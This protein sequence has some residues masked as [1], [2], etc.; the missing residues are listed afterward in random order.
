MIGLPFGSHLYFLEDVIYCEIGESLIMLFSTT[1]PRF[2][3]IWKLITPDLNDGGPIPVIV[4]S[5]QS[6]I[7]LQIRITVLS[8]HDVCY[9]NQ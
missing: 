2:N 3:E 6:F 1:N 8:K 5:K 4:F 7:V 9:I